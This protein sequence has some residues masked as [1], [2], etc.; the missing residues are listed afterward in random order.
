[1][2]SALRTRDF[3][4]LWLSQSVSVVG[5][6][7]VIVAIGLYVTRLTGNPGD[8]GVVLAAYS[9]PLVV[10]VLVGGVIAD[11]L[12]RQRVMVV[13]DLIRA[14]LHGT[15][16]VLIATGTVQIWQMVVI[17]ILFGTAEAFFGQRI[18]GWC[19]RR[20]PKLTSRPRRRSVA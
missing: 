17:G 16:A 18:P 12:P 20:W 4:L 9:L 2:L 3:L 11:R 6:A 10:F 14:V 19:R 13:S 5:D 7:L 15:L 1:V 8:V